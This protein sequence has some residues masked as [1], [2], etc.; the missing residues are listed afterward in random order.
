[1][2]F[3]ATPLF[4][5][6]L[7][8]VV[9]LIGQWLFKKSKGFFLFQPLFVGMVLGI[10]VL[11]VLAKFL[12]TTTAEVYTKAYKPGGDIIFWFI[13]PATIAFAVPLYKRNDVVKKN[14][15]VIL[16]GLV[17][18]TFISMVLITLVA[19]A[20]GLDSVGIKSML[21]QSATTAVAMP[22]TQS[23]GGN[24]SVTA[25]ACILNAVVIYAL[26]KQLV[27]WFNLNRDPLGAGLG[28]GAAGHTI[29]SAFALEMG[30]TQG[31]MA[32]VAVVATALVDNMLVPI[33]AHLIG[34]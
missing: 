21:S 34:L 31:A 12:G 10:A 33:F 4:G 3:L 20:V 18:G 29:G 17:C 1:M 2:K 8:L 14:W 23:I 15:L 22:L 26:G 32:A 25:M 28:L 6:F 11:I 24:P 19:K 30:S 13:T 7:S 5:V 16:L 9:F 27:K